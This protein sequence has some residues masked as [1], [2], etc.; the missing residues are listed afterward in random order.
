[1]SMPLL[2]LP[3]ST[4]RELSCLTPLHII[5]WMLLRL[6]VCLPPWYQLVRT[7][8]LMDPFWI[9]MQSLDRWL[10]HTCTLD[11]VQLYLLDWGPTGRRP[12]L[13]PELLRR[14]RCTARFGR[15]HIRSHF[16]SALLEP[17][18]TCELTPFGLLYPYPQSYGTLAA[19]DILLIALVDM[20][21]LR[22]GLRHRR[23][24]G[25]SSG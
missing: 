12:I 25:A 7:R 9:A 14:W 11:L 13:G 24:P 19:L 23:L 2:P 4:R 20:F 3:L 6:P 1:M 5:S 16:K 17:E 22:L 18:V 15:W 8:P 21:P 10:P